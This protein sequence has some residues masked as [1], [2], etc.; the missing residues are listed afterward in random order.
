MILCGNPPSGF[1][2]HSLKTT[3]ESK[4]LTTVSNMLKITRVNLY[5]S[6]HP[7]KKKQPAT[8]VLFLLI[9]DIYCYLQCTK[10]SGSIVYF[11]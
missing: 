8:L 2:E 3:S 7:S 6:S 9:L 11:D 10:F 5:T 4:I 1:L